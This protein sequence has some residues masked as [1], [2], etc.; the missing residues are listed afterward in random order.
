MSKLGLD[1]LDRTIH[2]TNTWLKEI[3]EDERVQR[4]ALDLLRYTESAVN[5]VNSVQNWR[6]LNLGFRF[7]IVSTLESLRLCTGVSRIK[8]SGATKR[9]SVRRFSWQLSQPVDLLF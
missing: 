6:P 9:R 1:I 4:A 2:D 3:S 5:C 8:F 7:R